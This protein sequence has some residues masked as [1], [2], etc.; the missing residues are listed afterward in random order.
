MLIFVRSSVCLSIWSNLHHSG[1]HLQEISQESVS[2]QS[3]LR[4]HSE[5]TKRELREQSVS[6]QSNKI[7]VNTV[8][9]YKY[10]VLFHS[11]YDQLLYG[12]CLPKI[13]P[14]K[15]APVHKVWCWSLG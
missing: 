12:N 14:V 6:T 10:C 1:S 15:K 5:S 7:R 9:F 13:L 3:A 2:S 8:R 4:E 11:T